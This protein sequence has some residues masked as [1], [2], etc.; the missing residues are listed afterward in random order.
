MGEFKKKYFGIFKLKRHSDFAMLKYHKIKRKK[1]DM[2]ES[3]EK[4]EKIKINESGKYN[5]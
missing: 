2:R 5:K 1:I 3:E 4:M